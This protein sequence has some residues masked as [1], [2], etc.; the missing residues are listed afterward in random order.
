[1]P[2]T[3]SLSQTFGYFVIRAQRK[4]FIST[5]FYVYHA[6]SVNLEK[7]STMGSAYSIPA[8]KHLEIPIFVI[9]FHERHVN[10]F[11]ADD[12]AVSVCRNSLETHYWGIKEE[13][14]LD[15]VVMFKCNKATVSSDSNVSHSEI[16]E[17]ASS[18]FDGRKLILSMCS[19][20]KELLGEG[21]FKMCACNLNWYT[22]VD[23]WF[24]HKLPI[25]LAC[26]DLDFCAI[27]LRFPDKL[28]FFRCPQEVVQALNFTVYDHWDKI[29]KA[30]DNAMFSYLKLK[31]DPWSQTRFR[32]SVKSYLLILKMLEC[33]ASHGWV[34]YSS[35][36]LD[37]RTDTLFFVQKR[38]TEE[39]W[40]FYSSMFAISL[41]RSD[42]LRVI[43]ADKTVVDCVRKTQEKNWKSVKEETSESDFVEFKLSGTPW[44]D[45]KDKCVPA[46]FLL[47]SIFCELRSLGWV[48]FNNIEMIFSATAKGVFHFCK[49]PPRQV[50]YCAISLK[51]AG[52]IYGVNI[53]QEIQEAL[54]KAFKPYFV[55][56]PVMVEMGNYSGIKWDLDG[57]PWSS[58]GNTALKFNGQL[59]VAHV[60]H[61]L[62]GFNYH[63]CHSA[64]YS[65]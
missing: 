55:E 37:D 22:D 33:M 25:P 53:N 24:F 14:M 40:T 26:K 21:Y 16:P 62:M 30:D 59:L 7:I 9:D 2:R 49:V 29:E 31:G 39:Q 3:L 34:L 54:T 15:D 61:I 11:N 6:F 56:Q 58:G 20:L 32:S 50:K 44:F 46:V 19:L 47:C 63:L 35:C 65:C 51:S 52:L 41:N 57:R 36:N 28:N 12:R 17:H 18:K 8:T 27:D 1:M 5:T 60:I 42:R 38:K 48:V 10:V 64:H 43:N 23:V 4:Q 45:D 13:K